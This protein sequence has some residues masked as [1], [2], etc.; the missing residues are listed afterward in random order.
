M[1][2]SIAWE[3]DSLVSPCEDEAVG[4]K[5][6]EEWCGNGRGLGRLRHSPIYVLLLVPGDRPGEVYFYGW[7]G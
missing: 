4:N 7:E 2:F 6:K 1:G 3:T 5:R